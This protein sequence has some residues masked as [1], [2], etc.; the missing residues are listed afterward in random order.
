MAAA[1]R[2]PPPPPPPKQQRDTV[3]VTADATAPK[4]KR[5]DTTPTTTITPATTT[6]AAVAAAE[7]PGPA[8]KKT[9]LE[10]PKPG[11]SARLGLA[12]AQGDTAAAAAFD[13]RI[14]DKYDVQVLGVASASKIQKRVVHVLQHIGRGAAITPAPTAATASTTTAAAVETTVASGKPRISILRARAA[15]A[16]KL[17]TIAEIAKRELEKEEER[18]GGEGEG[19]GEE[20]PGEGGASKTTDEGRWFQ[21]TALGEEVNEIPRGGG[22]GKGK[23][24]GKERKGKKSVGGDA[25]PGDGE[26]DGKGSDDDDDDDDDFETMKTPLERAL[27]RRPLLRGT[28]VMSI[29]LSR[30][31]VEEL[32]RRYGEQTNAAPP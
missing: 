24:K 1:P 25:A 15:D 3:T 16:G 8:T 31:P 5:T 28:P 7:G 14:E 27:E 23:S 19:E 18:G 12:T 21:Y 30:V 32:R 29:F 11:L 10:N 13:D 4:R 6:A 20:G 26:E 2:R 22:G 17:V 9:R